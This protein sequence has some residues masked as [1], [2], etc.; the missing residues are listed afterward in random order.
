VEV[1]RSAPTSKREMGEDG[2]LCLLDRLPFDLEGLVTAT[3]Q[4]AHR[5]P[6]G[7]RATWSGDQLLTKQKSMLSKIENMLSFL[8][9]SSSVSAA[10]TQECWNIKRI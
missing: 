3:R 8:Y 6:R 10:V 1:T 4:E 5:T 9:L 2:A 7:K